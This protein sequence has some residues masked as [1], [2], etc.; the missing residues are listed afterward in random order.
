MYNVVLPNEFNKPIGTLLLNRVNGARWRVLSSSLTDDFHKCTVVAELEQMP[1]KGLDPSTG[2]DYNESELYLGMTQTITLPSVDWKCV[3]IPGASPPVQITYVNQ[4]IPPSLRARVP[5]GIDDFTLVTGDRQWMAD[6]NYQIELRT[7]DL[8]DYAKLVAYSRRVKDV[9]FYLQNPLFDRMALDGYT[10]V[11]EMIHHDQNSCR[12]NAESI[13]CDIIRRDDSIL[14]NVSRF[15]LNF[16]EYLNEAYYA[17]TRYMWMPLLPRDEMNSDELYLASLEI[18][19]TLGI[20]DS[21]MTRTT[22]VEG[23]DWRRIF[24]YGD[25]LTIQKLHQLNP[26][27]LR[28]MTHIGKENHAKTIHS[29]LNDTFCIRNHDYLHENIHRL[30]AVYKIFYPG[31]I[32]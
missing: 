12:K 8:R 29:H 19:Q 24:Q 23:S 21:K 25:V 27:V 6:I 16:L 9:C 4:Q 1:T 7:L 5:V 2:A 10:D 31:F 17:V 22:T 32:E 18:L 13:C 28:A 11:N 15:Q 26:N 20:L 3:L 14:S 30:Q